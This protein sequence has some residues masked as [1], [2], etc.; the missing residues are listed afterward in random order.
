MATEKIIEQILSIHPE[1]SRKKILER[2]QKEK[3]KTGG[4]IA[5]VILLRTIAAELDVEIPSEASMPT[6]SIGDLVPGLNDVTVVGRVVAVFPSK[7]FEGNKSGKVASLLIADKNSILRV[8]LWNDKASLIE[9][10][11]VKVGQIIRLCHG[12]TREG[13]SGRVELHL[14]DRGEIR[15]DPRDVKAVDYPTISRFVTK[16]AEI[17]PAYKNK[18]VNIIG[19][20]EEAFP[21]STF[22]RK[23]SSSGKVMR[24]VLADETGEI[25]VVVW[26]E[27]VDELEKAVKKGVKLQVVNAK[28][29]KAISEG[30]E[31][32]VNAG[33]YVEKLAP[34]EEFL[35]IADLKEGLDNVN[36][37]GEVATKPMLRDV[38]TSK[39]ELVK[40][41]VFELRDETGRMWISAWRRHADSV[42]GLKLGDRV[43]IKNAYV[44]KGFGDQ[45]EISTKSKTR[46]TIFPRIET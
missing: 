15:I 11:R 46:I 41:A 7:T 23:N 25:S 37:E 20:V 17:T 45:P 6:L 3:R 42:K 1:I 9:S 43:I 31:I 19:V 39:G 16:I 35:K 22:E 28:V 21:V 30:L 12:Y 18:K 33:T 10:G 2:L 38:K 26:N 34:A 36:A 24:F 44:K 4:L 40:L 27:K 13:Y 8:A 5:D 14:G 32:H 29:K